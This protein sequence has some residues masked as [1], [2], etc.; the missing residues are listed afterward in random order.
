MIHNT[1]IIHPTAM[2]GSNVHIGPY[3]IIEEG[4]EIQDNCSIG[5]HA[6]VGKWTILAKGCHVFPHAAIG[7]E[8]QD[9]KYKGEKTFLTVGENTVIR[10]FATINRGTGEGRGKTTLGKNN[11]LMS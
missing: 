6:I 8:P 3:A 2:I 7:T 11:F 5:S 4:V 1:A 9:L 10:E